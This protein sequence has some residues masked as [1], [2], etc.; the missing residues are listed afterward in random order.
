LY[1]HAYINVQQLKNEHSAETMSP[2]DD[3]ST[4]LSRSEDSTQH[5]NGTLQIMIRW[6]ICVIFIIGNFF[7]VTMPLIQIHNPNRPNW[8]IETWVLTVVVGFSYCIGALAAVYI[9]AIC[10]TIRFEKG[11]SNEGVYHHQYRW[12]LEYPDNCWKFPD[13][14]L[15]WKRLFL[16]E[17]SITGEQQRLM[18][19]RS[20]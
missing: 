18:D 2:V 1:S 15:L 13:R 5:A 8:M 4:G 3:V 16:V 17:T 19:G 6:F 12:I 7:V 11:R 9:L 14:K 20:Q 10:I